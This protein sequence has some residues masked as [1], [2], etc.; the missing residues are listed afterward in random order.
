MAVTFVTKPKE[1]KVSKKMQSVIKS[2]VDALYVRVPE[3]EHAKELIKSFDGDK[4]KLK[5]LIPEDW[6]P[7]DE[8]VF[9][10]VLADAKFSPAANKRE[11]TDIKRFH[12]LVGD[13]VFYAVATVPL[14]EV[15]KYLTEVEAEEIVS[16]MR[17]GP[18]T[19]KLTRKD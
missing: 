17:V 1:V 4:A 13:D 16:S 18:R 2:L 3:V 19:F 11:I 10:G 6:N 8:V 5:K 9:S 12:E 14:K 7:E 15:D